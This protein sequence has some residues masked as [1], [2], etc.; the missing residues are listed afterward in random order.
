M[1]LNDDGIFL[2]AHLLRMSRLSGTCSFISR[3]SRV[4]G[5][6]FILFGALPD[7]VKVLPFYEV[8]GLRVPL[9]T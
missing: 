9:C 4:M 2:K 7:V 5:D 3:L 1:R 8:R 6:A